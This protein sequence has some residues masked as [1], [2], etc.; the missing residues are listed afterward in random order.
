MPLSP[1][2]R[3]LID[4]VSLW[5]RRPRPWEIVAFQEDRGDK[6]WSVKRAIAGAGQKV[7]LSDGD[8]YLN[9]RLLRKTLAQFRAI[10]IPIHNDAFRPSI[11]PTLPDRWLGEPSRTGWTRN[12]QG[13]ECSGRWNGQSSRTNRVDWLE[14]HPWT[15]RANPVPPAARTDPSPILD[16][17]G[18][19]QSCSRGALHT[20]HD[21][22]LTVRV[23][24]QGN[25][26]VVARMAD[27]G[28]LFHVVLSPKAGR[29]RLL[30]NDQAVLTG[31][32][33]F[34]NAPF[35]LELALCDGRVIVAINRLV[36]FEYAFQPEKLQTDG[37]VSS[38]QLA[39]GV[40]GVRV[41]LGWPRIDRDVYYLGPHN[42][43]RWSAPGS[44]PEG[45]WFVLGD[46]VPV[47]LDSRQGRSISA[48]DLLGTIIRYP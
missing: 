15:C 44:I 42:E 11:D 9:D 27:R 30:D 10:A 19:N 47:S 38:K 29:Y 2:R 36:L 16:D 48:K 25:G 26:R 33:R 17:Y 37:T 12:D 3:V 4:P 23:Q 40:V 34:R 32:R 14:Y 1:G 35:V 43:V 41:Q 45:H 39:I 5:W 6:W 28:H 21:V 13:Y 31:R 20:V 24:C 8:V 18:Y 7:T 46:N 22:L